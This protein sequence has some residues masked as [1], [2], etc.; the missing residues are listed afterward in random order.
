M[1]ADASLNNLTAKAM[2]GEQAQRRN[3]EARSAGTAYN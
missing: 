1:R 3:Y 2:N